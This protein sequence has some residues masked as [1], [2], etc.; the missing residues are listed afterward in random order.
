MKSY[1]K[2]T[3]Y[4]NWIVVAVVLTFVGCNRHREENKV[5]QTLSFTEI[6]KVDADMPVAFEVNGNSLFIT[7]YSGDKLVK[8][9]NL[10]SKEIVRS[11][12]Q[13]G[14]G[15][16]EALSPI[17]AFV[18]KDSIIV[19]SRP[20]MSLISIPLNHSAGVKELKNGVVLPFMVSDLFK[21]NDNGFIA[22]IIPFGADD[23]IKGKRFMLIDRYGQQNGLFGSYPKI[24][25]KDKTVSDDVLAHF[26]QTLS[27]LFPNDT[28]MIAL[29]NY[30][31]SKYVDRGDGF[32]LKSEKMLIPY[33]YEYQDAT[34][35]SS[36]ITKRKDD[37]ERGIN[38]AVLWNGKILV[39]RRYADSEDVDKV[40]FELYDTDGHLEQQLYP[41]QNVY[42]PFAITS[43]GYILA[44]GGESEGGMILLKSTTN[45]M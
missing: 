34:E 7:D 27:V 22:S 19:Y 9:F 16:G 45:L 13:R 30:V 17:S 31:M 2:N 18:G 10:D 11:L 6:A 12:V 33:E 44:N 29:T 36:A 8:E 23:S 15:P 43:E 24:I 35:T 14:N 38:G 39:S 20:I 32:T 42:Y 28:I 26:H 5:E 40:Y 41:E 21:M 3:N 4:I 37:M 25:D 1:I